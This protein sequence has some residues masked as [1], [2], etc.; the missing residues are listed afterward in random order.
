M[1]LLPLG[2]IGM[3]VGMMIYTVLP[4]VIIAALLAL[5]W[6]IFSIDIFIRGIKARRTEKNGREPLVKV[7]SMLTN[8]EDEDSDSVEFVDRDDN[9]RN[10]LDDHLENDPKMCSL[11]SESKSVS[12]SVRPRN[13][14]LD[15]LGISQT[16]R[17]LAKS[18]QIP[19]R[20]Q[21]NTSASRSDILTYL[22]SQMHYLEEGDSE[23]E[24]NIQLL[25]RI[26]QAYTQRKNSDFSN[27]HKDGELMELQAL[28]E[29]KIKKGIEKNKRKLRE[30]Q[31]SEGYHFT[32]KSLF[33][34]F[35]LLLLILNILSRGLLEESLFGIKQCTFEDWLSFILIG[36]SCFILA[37]SS[38]SYLNFTYKNKRK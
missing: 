33:I 8:E 3:M 6:G 18:G 35:G 26:Q 5:F 24:D 22:F 23:A 11:N 20:I 13:K 31:V 21:S 14:T 2:I 34:T 28:M 27:I 15:R 25:E 36:V 38:I 37:L 1:I 12:Q 17:N 16:S 7:S 9:N 30:I 29:K 10:F 19:V 4:M 32:T